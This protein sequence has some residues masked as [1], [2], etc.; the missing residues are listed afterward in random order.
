MAAGS[1][2]H[3]LREWP[4][5]YHP[6]A[7]VAIESRITASRG[8]IGPQ[9]QSRQA[10]RPQSSLAR[11]PGLCAVKCLIPLGKPAR[12]SLTRSWTALWGANHA[13]GLP[14]RHYR[15]SHLGAETAE[16]NLEV[17]RGD[18]R[19]PG[20]RPR[21]LDVVL[22]V[23]A[24][25]GAVPAAPAPAVLGVPLPLAGR[26]RAGPRARPQPGVGMEQG[27]AEGTALPTASPRGTGHEGTSTEESATITPPEG[28]RRSGAERLTGCD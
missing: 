26:G 16:D 14:V 6:T 20:G 3:L 28:T 9:P 22:V 17:A 18:R 2:G 7:R 25:D 27:L 1:L 21:G 23:R 12:S 13:W 8:L 11:G 15:V 19:R 10:L 5:V 4:P 24:G